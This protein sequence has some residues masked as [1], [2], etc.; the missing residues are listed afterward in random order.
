MG[1]YWDGGDYDSYYGCFFFKWYFNV[2]I[3]Y[4]D[5][6]L[7]FVNI[8]FEGVKIVVKVFGIYW[9]YKIVSYV[10]EF[11]VGFYNFVN[12]DGY[13]VIVRMLVKYDVFFNFICVEFC[14]L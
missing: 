12:C 4:G 3:E 5:C 8:V 1:F 14:I 9:W 6:V 7:I 11:V 10:V 13:V 2:F